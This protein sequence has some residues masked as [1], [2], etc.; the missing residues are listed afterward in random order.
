MAQ[1]IRTGQDLTPEAVIRS[2]A[3]KHGI[4]PVRTVTDDWADAI[5]R[6]SGDEVIANEIEDLVVNLRRRGVISAKEATALYGDYL[7]SA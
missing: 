3:E 7:A 5:T 6:L 1:A 4:S 2:L